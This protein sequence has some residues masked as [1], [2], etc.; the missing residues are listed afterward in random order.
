MSISNRQILDHVKRWQ[1]ASYVHSLTCGNES[2]HGDLVAEERDG[3]VILRCVDCDFVQEEIP[4]YLLK[5]KLVI[6]GE[7]L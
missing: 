3:K 7:E 1:Q 4:S 2:S 5:A 6:I